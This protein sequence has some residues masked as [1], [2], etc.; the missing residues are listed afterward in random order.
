MLKSGGHIF[1]GEQYTAK[2]TR[3][4]VNSLSLDF[5]SNNAE[6]LDSE[7][8]ILAAGC[9]WGVQALLNQQQGVIYTQ[10]GYIRDDRLDPDYNIV[11]SG[12]TTFVEAVRVIYDPQ[13]I[14][15]TDVIKLFFE[16]IHLSLVIL[17]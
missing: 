11:C 13:I 3:Y 15:Y 16:I 7:E 5:I 6:L 4:C 17:P 12:K 9:F 8:I 2:N 10:V 14:S 1:Y